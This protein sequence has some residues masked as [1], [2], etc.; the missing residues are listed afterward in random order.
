MPRIVRAE[1]LSYYNSA[2]NSDKVFN[3]FLIEDDDGTYRCVTEH[4]RRGNNLV[5]NTLCTRQRRETAESKLR[6]KLNA[7]RY[8]RETP[9][10]DGPF[11]YNYSQLASEYSFNSQA[12]SYNLPPETQQSG[13]TIEP[14]SNVITFP[15]EK[16]EKHVNKPKQNGI[17]NSDQ[18][19]SLEL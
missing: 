13:K 5:R 12:S 1:Y 16:T 18:F 10:T 6:E 7:K 11:G 8:H 3:V 15:V 17:L 9:Y 19:D 4:G 2:R 14:K